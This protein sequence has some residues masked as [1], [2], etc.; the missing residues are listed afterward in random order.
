[1]A[2]Y[3][4]IIVGAGPSG[5]IAGHTWLT[6]HPQS[7]VVILEAGATAGG[8]WSRD[9]IYPTMM[10]QTPFGMLEYGCYPMSSPRQSFHD[11]FPGDHVC[12][13]LEEF[14]QSVEFEG[15]T[16]KERIHFESRV[17]QIRKT[18][19]QWTVR[20]SES[21]QARSPKLIVATGPTSA[22]NI[23]QCLREKTTV[24]VFHSKDLGSNAA[25]LT[26]ATVQDVAVIGGSKS[27]F[28]AVYLLAKANKNVSWIIRPGG[29]G[30][31]WLAPPE[32]AAGFANAHEM[33]SLKLIAKTSPCIF[34]PVYG[35]MRFFHQS[36]VGRWA[37]RA[38]WKR[39][40]AM[41][42]T[43]ARYQ[44]DENFAQL[45]P[46]RP[47][48]WASDVASQNT[49]D[50]WDVISKAT[51]L[52]DEAVK[53]EEGSLIL[54]CGKNVV[55][56]AVVAC[57]G[58]DHS[59]PMFTMEDAIELGLPISMRH[60]P[61][62]TEKHWD[63][64]ISTA[65]NT[66]IQRFPAL[67]ETDISPENKTATSPNH[68]YRA[69]APLKDSDRSI[70]ILGQIGTSQSFIVAE[71]QSLWAVAYLTGQLGIPSFSA[72][73]EDVAMRIAWR[74]RRYLGDGHTM[75]FDQIAV[76]DIHFQIH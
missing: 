36:R 18:G 24:P 3:D 63:T 23:P 21:L 17:V 33:I 73:E 64:L 15:R 56:D 59:Y 5:L 47:A 44:R 27:A 57:T 69:I 67:A 65:D 29:Q 34:D 72:M 1:M 22:P 6:L 76:S 58:W 7:N 25:L 61:P 46:D 70:A 68:L 71:I 11:L 38:I 35:L 66:I 2:E 26:S 60:M 55:C 40:E 13:Y 48:Y 41:W 14:A 16:L 37:V 51:V 62:P 31:G 10:T 8:V 45:K 32:G 75:P 39:V 42:C 30:P 54:T 74:R 4:L 43:K 9:R 53:I 49:P 50:T 28:D 52:R 19:N 20:T 12:Q